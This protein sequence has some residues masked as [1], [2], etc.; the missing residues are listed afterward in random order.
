MRNSTEQST[1]Y[2][3]LHWILLCIGLPV[4]VLLCMVS[5]L[6]SSQAAARNRTHAQVAQSSTLMVDGALGEQTTIRGFLLSL[7]IGGVGLWTVRTSATLT[8]TVLVLDLGI[9]EDGLLPAGNWVYINAQVELGGLVVATEIRLDDYKP[10]EVVARLA[11]GVVPATIAEQYDLTIKST[12][13][14]E[15]NIYLFTTPQ[16][17]DDVPE[18]V[19][20]L[21]A[22][23]ED[24]ILWAEPNYYSDTPEG[25]PYKT[26]RWGGVEPSGYTNQAAFSQINL[27][28]AQAHYLGDQ[29][30]V[31]LLDTGIDFNHPALAGRWLP[32]YDLVA[33]DADPQDEGPGMGWGHG[34]HIAGIILAIAPN[35][36]ILPVRVLDSEG[37]GE[38]F[39]L[40]QA[41]DRVVSDGAKVINLSLG[42]DPDPEV[43][44]ELIDHAVGQGVIIVAAAGNDNTNT[45]QYPIG[46]AGVLG[47]TA[48]DDANHKADFANYGDWV[49]LAAP[50]VGITSTI[51]G[52]EG[53]G[54][55]SWSGTSMA[56]A[57]VSGAAALARQKFPISS[58]MEITQLLTTYA[59]SLDAENPEY[60]GKLLDIGAAL[61]ADLAQT[62]PTETPQPTATSTPDPTGSGTPAE[63]LTPTPSPTLTLDVTPSPDPVEGQTVQLYLPLVDR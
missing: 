24:D 23:A 14:A 6:A 9:L 57:F 46:Y 3:Q 34:T 53:S 1:L 16:P 12:A 40:A 7:P 59:A 11:N 47:V 35:S 2:L 49:E 41:I 50:G 21:E 62:P 42:M 37:R 60:I 22:D 13:L 33:D 36:T 44:R 52:P 28:P 45:V 29:I 25:N 43:L 61:T 8:Q 27:A 18:L 15:H 58:T 55:A 30:I 56:T 48:L 38:V 20:Q 19:D 5:G 32:G 39:D 26:W 51:V 31:A 4:L 63:T 10:G 17:E 54:Y